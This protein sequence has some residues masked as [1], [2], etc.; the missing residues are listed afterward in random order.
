MNIGIL[1]FLGTNCDYDIKEYC[2]VLGHSSE[3]IWYKDHFDEKKYDLI[4]I[5]GG[6]SYGDYLRAG[7]LSS[8]TPVIQSLKSAID[9]GVPVLGICNGFQILC[10]MQALPGVLLK[11]QNDKFIDKWVDLEV[12]SSSYFLNSNVNKGDIFRLPIAHGEGRFFAPKDQIKKMWDLDQIFI[13]YKENING[14]VDSIAGISS[15]DK[16]II[17][18]MPHPERAFAQYLG[19]MDGVL[20]L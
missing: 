19:G 8:R 7:V 3:F 1:R 2:Q 17:G 15:I 6:F 13:T 18:M 10:E 14:S 9:R 20:F 4:I 16:K 11:N 12:R 5:P